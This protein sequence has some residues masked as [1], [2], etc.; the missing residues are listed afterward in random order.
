MLWLMCVESIALNVAAKNKYEQL[1][2]YESVE[3]FWIFH[4]AKVPV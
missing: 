4:L 2:A 3:L 1:R